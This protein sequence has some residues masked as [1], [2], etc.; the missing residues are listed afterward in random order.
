MADRETAERVAEPVPGPST[1]RLHAIAAESGA[2]LVAG[3]V[4]RDEESSHLFNS[5]VLIGPERV[6]GVYRKLHLAGED[7]AWACPGDR[8]LPA[9]DIPIGR[10]GMLIGYD[11]LFP[12]AARS[13][14]IDGADIIAC[15]SLLTWPGVQPFG[16]TAVPLPELV[17]R[18]PT[19]SHFHLW[20]E[21]ERENQAHV[22]F[23]NGA[24]PWMGWSGI[25]AA[26]LESEWRREALVEGDREGVATLEI[27]TDGVVRVKDLVGMRMPI[28]YDAMQAP[29][30]TAARIARERGARPEAWLTAERQPM[31]SSAG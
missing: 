7:R 13:L 5:A 12:E 1:K 19:A 28:W 14:A 10:V 18:G 29:R 23:A 6:I 17:D 21:R 22:L 8:G 25:F 20:R 30:E 16:E 31:E 27:A 15:P 4:E 11:A 24:G 2:H 26:V 3:I 9:F